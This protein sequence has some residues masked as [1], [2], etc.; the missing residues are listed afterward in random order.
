[1]SLRQL[2]LSFLLLLLMPLAEAAAPVRQNTYVEG[3][4]IEPDSVMDNEDA[5]FE[6][7]QNGTD[8]IRAG[9]VTTATIQDS[10]VTSAKIA[11]GTITTSDL[12]FTIAGGAL[13]PSGA[14]YFMLS[15]NCPSGTTDVS[16][17]YA[18]RF[19]RV[20]ASNPS[21]LGGADTHTHTAGTY[22]APSHT[23][24]G[25]TAIE[26]QPA[27]DGSGGSLGADDDHTHPFTTDAGGSGAITGTSAS[28]DNIP[29]FAY[30]R[31]CQ[32]Q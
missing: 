24:A 11:D 13:L 27:A 1:M 10:A 12:A 23:H 6:Y 7:L 8:T 28:G 18:N 20:S 19:L 32:V 25:T 16:A 26:T 21:T 15:G 5:I 29:A 2:S 22:A 30:G 9:A 31:L 17:T 4:D 3:T 14:V